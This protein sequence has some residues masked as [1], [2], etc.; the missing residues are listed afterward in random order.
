MGALIR[1]HWDRLGPV[2]FHEGAV[3]FLFVSLVALWF[4]REPEFMT[5]W[6]D[7]LPEENEVGDEVSVA[8][9]TPAILVCLLLFFLPAR[10]HFAAGILRGKVVFLER[11]RRSTG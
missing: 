8:D 7:L 4:F 11:L 9:G 5:G 10:P 1:H 6:A 2:S 3:L